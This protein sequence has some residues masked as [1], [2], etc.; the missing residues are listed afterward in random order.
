MSSRKNM[1][2][3]VWEC[4]DCRQQMRQRRDKAKP[5]KCQTCRSTNLIDVEQAIIDEA[6]SVADHE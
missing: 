4:A 1:Q 6:F 3:R 2:K 5:S